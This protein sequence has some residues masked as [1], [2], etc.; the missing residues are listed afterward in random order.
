M[1]SNGAEIW[2]GSGPIRSGKQDEDLL[3]EDE[4]TLN[5]WCCIEFEVKGEDIR[6]EEEPRDGPDDEEYSDACQPGMKRAEIHLCQGS[7]PLKI[8]TG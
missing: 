5:I 7:G 1:E 6:Q 8:K 2:S 3:K 4:K